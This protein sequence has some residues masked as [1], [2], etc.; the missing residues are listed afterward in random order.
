VS[1]PSCWAPTIPSS[2]A[3]AEPLDSVA[4]AVA[5]ARAILRDT[6]SGLLYL[7]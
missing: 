2:C 6:A 1:K 4:V 5:E 7:T 3:D